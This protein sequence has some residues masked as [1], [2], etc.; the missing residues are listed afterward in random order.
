MSTGTAIFFM[1]VRKHADNMPARVG[2]EA[3]LREIVGLMATKKFTAVNIVDTDNRPIGIITEQDIVRRVAFNADPDQPA[4]DIM[5]PHVRSISEDEAL[6][7]AI[8]RMRRLGHRH[9]PVVDDEG[10]LSGMLDLHETMVLASGDLVSRIDELTRDDSIDGQREIKAA[11][12]DV[13]RQLLAD[14]VPAPEV[15]AL[16]THINN[17]IYRSMLRRNLEK[18]AGG[19][20]G[21]P[22]IP[23]AMI[24]MGSGGRGENYLYPDQDYGF[25]LADYEDRQ[26]QKIDAW[27]NELAEHLSADLDAV[28]LPYCSGDV[29]ATNPVWRK[30]ISQWK[31]QIDSWKRSTKG[32][33]ALHFDIFFDF[34]GSRGDATLTAQLRRHVTEQTKG[35]EPFLRTIHALSRDHITAKRWFGRFA[36]ERKNNENKGKV[37]MKLYGSLPL[38]EGVR[39]LALREGVT[40]T[41]TLARLTALHD[42]SAI[43]D[44]DYDDLS[45]AYETICELLLR[46]QIA[47]FTAG[48]KVSNFIHPR[49]LSGRMRRRLRYAFRAIENLQ[50]RINFEVGG[51]IF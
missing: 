17:D 28:G 30:S 48:R 21:D 47:D 10:R 23:F 11:Q 12:V 50:K 41:G 34:R 15:Q 13:A 49:T 8:A 26:H 5:S 4:S 46:Q 32:E 33:A 16:L 19:G 45:G 39:L 7:I 38:V 37:N 18:M 9:M 27:F 51:E 40:A 43:N 36:T 31:D 3:S 29:M 25:V 24:I 35:N 44:E 2:P 1:H 14:N 6:F 42:G 20:K 22:P